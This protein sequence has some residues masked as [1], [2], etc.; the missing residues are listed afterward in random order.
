MEM[1]NSSLSDWTHYEINTAT[2][3]AMLCAAINIFI[4]IGNILVI[5][6]FFKMS[7]LQIQHYYMLGLVFADIAI[8]IQNSIIVFFLVKGDVWMNGAVCFVTGSASVTAATA[9]SL[10]HTAMSLDRW[11]SIQFP[12]K[13]LQFKDDLK[14]KRIVIAII[15]LIY[16][17]PSPLLYLTW[18]TYQI[19]FYFD[20]YVPY[21]IADVGEEGMWGLL[22]AG[23]LSIAIPCVV[24]VFTNTRILMRITSMQGANRKRI[25]TAVKTVLT[26]LAVYYI[27]WMPM[28]IWT[29]WDLVADTHPAG[30]YGYFAVQMLV[31]NSG[32]SFLIYYNTLKRFRARFQAAIEGAKSSQMFREVWRSAVTAASRHTAETTSGDKPHEQ[33][34]ASSRGREASHSSEA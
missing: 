23:A 4:I 34:Q 22:L 14:S 29:V 2:E 27:C 16:I 10:I 7:K 8:F 25:I 13:Y 11:V 15:T 3:Y 18:R 24:Q 30:W 31:L 21:C 28:G 17:L 26:T 5:F 19:S 12:V 32:M 9:T 1:G 6:T 33:G 20:T